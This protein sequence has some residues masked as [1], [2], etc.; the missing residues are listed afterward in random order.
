MSETGA[1]S[2]EP[3]RRAR[4]LREQIAYHDDR[5]YQLDSPEI[6][7]ADYDA[8]VEELRTIE[9][10]HPVLVTP[11]SPTRRVGGG[12][13]PLF[14]PVTHRTPMMSLDDAFGIDQLH[15]WFERMARDRPRDSRRRLRV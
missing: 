13:S 7:D 8:L 10:R 5:Y 2:A 6:A 14:S 3:A 12:L 1:G 11:D 9:E 15:A 4:Q